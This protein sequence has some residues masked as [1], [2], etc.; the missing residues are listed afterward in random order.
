MAKIGDAE[1]HARD[2]IRSSCCIL[3]VGSFKERMYMDIGSNSIMDG[4]QNWKTHEKM[5][6]PKMIGICLVLR[7]GTNCSQLLETV[8]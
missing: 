6:V 4:G 8:E 7:G 5:S 3:G 2:N 1:G